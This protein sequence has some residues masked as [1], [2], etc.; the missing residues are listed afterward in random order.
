MSLAVAAGGAAPAVLVAAAGGDTGRGPGGRLAAAQPR[1]EAAEDAGEEEG[2]EA[3]QHVRVAEAEAG[4]VDEA[5]VAED[6][7]AAQEAQL[8]RL[9]ELHCG[10]AAAES[11]EAEAG[12]EGDRVPPPAGLASSVQDGAATGAQPPQPHADNSES[13]RTSE[14]A[15]AA[16]PAMQRAAAAG[17]PHPPA[18]PAEKPT[19]DQ[20]EHQPHQQNQQQQPCQGPLTA[21]D[22]VEVALAATGAPAASVEDIAEVLGGW[23]LRRGRPQRSGAVRG[24]SSS[25]DDGSHAK[26]RTS[27][28]G[29]AAVAASWPGWKALSQLCAREDGAGGAGGEAGVSGAAASAAVPALTAAR[30][31]DTLLRAGAGTGDSDAGSGA[32]TGTGLLHQRVR[33]VLESERAASGR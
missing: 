1:H 15:V 21:E 16:A 29:A 20:Q 11:E 18:S 3:T 2:A 10:L 32:G 7:G 12:G 9:L 23:W 13:E 8:L 27:I 28:S 33:A 25:G 22:V 17:A 5:E 30:P 31:A 4:E 14:S 24:G 26:R 6:W 19:T